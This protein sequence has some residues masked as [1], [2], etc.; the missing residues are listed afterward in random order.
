MNSSIATKEAEAC[1]ALHL[2]F[3]TFVSCL[4]YTRQMLAA[5]W[6]EPEVYHQCN[7]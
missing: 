7:I 1:A 2:V 4:G 3:E 6:G 5:W